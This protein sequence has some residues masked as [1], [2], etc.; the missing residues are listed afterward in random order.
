MVH[1]KELRVHAINMKPKTENW[2]EKQLRTDNQGK[3]Y[4]FVLWDDTQGVFRLKKCAH[5]HLWTG[6]S[7][8]AAENGGSE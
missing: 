6:A 8:R 4:S 2:T 3:E 1:G 7:G 5:K